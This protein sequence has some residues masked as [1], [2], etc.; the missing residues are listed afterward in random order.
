M[1]LKD[2]DALVTEGRAISKQIEELQKQIDEYEE[3]EKAITAK[4]IP[5][6]LIDD[7]NALRD[8]INKDVKE[9]E[10]IGNA[11][12]DEKLRAI[13]EDMEKAHLKLNGEREK[14]EQERNKVALKV[15]KIKDRLIP[16]LQ[17]ETKKYL[18]EYEDLMSAELTEDKSKVVIKKF[19]HLQEWKRQ[20]K[21]KFK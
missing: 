8:K 11:I 9:L 5:Q 17:K 14:L 21:A 19:S 2:K 6:K 18:G 13:P 12:R 16:K 3:K 20:F 1:W 7:G 10:R 15:Q 4:V